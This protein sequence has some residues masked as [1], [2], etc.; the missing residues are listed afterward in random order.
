MKYLDILDITARCRTIL[1]ALG[2]NDQE[3]LL[4]LDIESLKGNRVARYFPYYT[5]VIITDKVIAEIKNQQLNI[6]TK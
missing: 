4:N 3:S 1:H 5:G 6:T 2:V